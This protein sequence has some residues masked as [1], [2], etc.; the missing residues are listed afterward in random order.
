MKPGAGQGSPLRVAPLYTRYCDEHFPCLGPSCPTSRAPHHGQC[1]LAG[2]VDAEEG[3]GAEIVLDRAV[4]NVA[5]GV[6]PCGDGNRLSNSVKKR[7]AMAGSGLEAAVV[8][9]GSAVEGRGGAGCVLLRFVLFFDFVVDVPVV[10]VV[11]WC[12][13]RYCARQGIWSRQ[14]SRGVPLLHFLDKVLTCPLLRRLVHEGGSSWTR[15]RH[16]R[17]CDDWCMEV[18]FLNKVLTCPL[19]RRQVLGV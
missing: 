2:P 19:L 13:S 4:P 10:Q 11:F 14:C 1:F 5:A 8:V 12:L 18:Q 15:L 9:G 16:A 7:Q 6:G 3:A 17:C